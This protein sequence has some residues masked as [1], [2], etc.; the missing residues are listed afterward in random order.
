MAKCLVLHHIYTG[1]C[2]FSDDLFNINYILGIL[3]CERGRV[4][5]SFYLVYFENID[6]GQVL[7]GTH[8]VAY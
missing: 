3:Y 6:R 5:D 7:T 8:F 2:P 1:Y 4:E